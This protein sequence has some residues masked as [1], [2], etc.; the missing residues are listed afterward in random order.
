[1]LNYNNSKVIKT[2]DLKNYKLVHVFIILFYNLHILH[3]RSF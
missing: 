1:M 3:S 2:I